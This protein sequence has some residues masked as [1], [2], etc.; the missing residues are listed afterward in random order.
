MQYSGIKLTSNVGTINKLKPLKLSQCLKGVYDF[1]YKFLSADSKDSLNLVVG[2]GL[3]S[4][5][6]D[7]GVSWTQAKSFSFKYNKNLTDIKL[8]VDSRSASFGL[9][10]SDRINLSNP[11]VQLT[12][13]NNF[14]F[15]LP[16]TRYQAWGMGQIDS[17]TGLN[18][19]NGQV[20]RSDSLIGIKITE[21]IGGDDVSDYAKFSLSATSDIKL[22]TNNAIAQI[23]NYK[24]Q[25]VIDSS[26]SYDSVLEGHL[27][28]GTY[29]IGFSTESS[30]VG[31]FTSSLSFI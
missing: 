27:A 22:E 18:W 12:F 26:D 15:D 10:A 14:D 13:G 1:N 16:D 8:R 3:I 24:G 21:A 17:L 30:T 25:V 5:S 20:T 2:S 19:N 4:V 6:L 29:Y 9:V 23:I 28:A 31:S 7:N 11:T